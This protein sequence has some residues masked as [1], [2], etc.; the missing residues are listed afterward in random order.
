MFLLEFLTICRRGLVYQW[1]D[2]SRE[3]GCILPSVSSARFLRPRN[4]RLQN[5]EKQYEE[6]ALRH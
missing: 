3:I 4:A 2:C 6:E 1:K 5:G